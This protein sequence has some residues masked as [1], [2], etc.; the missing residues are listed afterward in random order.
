MLLFLCNDILDV[1]NRDTGST[2]IIPHIGVV[3][4]FSYIIK[5]GS[6]CISLAVKIDLT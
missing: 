2:D 5:L 6:V 1:R 3:M 4:V